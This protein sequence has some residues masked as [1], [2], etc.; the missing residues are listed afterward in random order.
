MTNITDFGVVTFQINH[1]AVA[2][3]VGIEEREHR[4]A[5]ACRAA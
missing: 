1:L 2:G 4:R 5:V 3:G